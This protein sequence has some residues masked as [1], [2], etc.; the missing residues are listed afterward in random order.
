MLFVK[1][2][3]RHV[4]ISLSFLPLVH[5]FSRKPDVETLRRR[6]AAG[7][8]QAEID[9]AS[10]YATGS[11][12][13]A[14]A[15]E[16]HRWLEQATSQL[17]LSRTNPFS[18]RIYRVGGDVKPPYAIYTPDPPVGTRYGLV[19]LRAVLGADGRVKEATVSRSQG[20][21]LDRKAIEA[22]RRWM[23]RPATLYGYPVSVEIMIEVVMPTRAMR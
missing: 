18:L 2:F 17:P 5:A 3:A 10:A 8:L 1:S 20:K 21:D 9:L 15:A 23:F 4:V 7:E 13:N 16:A 19:V 22:V 11:G 14:D 12:V 6:A